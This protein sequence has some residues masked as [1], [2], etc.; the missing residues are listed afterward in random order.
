MHFH[1]IISVPRINRICRT[2]LLDLIL[3]VN[4][5]ASEGEGEPYVVLVKWNWNW[6]SRKEVKGRGV[7]R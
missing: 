7:I 3:C 5:T 2:I 6:K 1:S 4:K